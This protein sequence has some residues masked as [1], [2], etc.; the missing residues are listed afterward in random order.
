MDISLRSIPIINGNYW[1]QT[2][3]LLPSNLHEPKT[4]K[5]L[6]RHDLDLK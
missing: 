5:Q 2:F 3:N 1:I 4:V 6:I